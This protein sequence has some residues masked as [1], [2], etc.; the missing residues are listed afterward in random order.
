[1]AKVVH[2]NFATKQVTYTLELF[3]EDF[4]IRAERLI[5]ESVYE[6]QHLAVQRAKALGNIRSLML[7]E[8]RPSARKGSERALFVMLK[9]EI[10]NFESEG[11]ELC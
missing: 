9:D 2:V 11:A 7:F 1:M 8:G 4:S 5:A 10:T 3:R 6:A